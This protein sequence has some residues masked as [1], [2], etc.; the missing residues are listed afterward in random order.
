MIPTANDFDF[1]I[2]GS[3]ILRKI[4]V[5][6]IVPEEYD[7][8]A[9]YPP[10]AIRKT[11]IAKERSDDGILGIG[12]EIIRGYHLAGFCAVGI[13]GIHSVFLDDK[14]R[15]EAARELAMHQAINQHLA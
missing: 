7:P 12:A 5:V 3:S 10:P 4:N 8:D 2:S 13:G 1:S 9:V 11:D 6:E 15:D 14:L